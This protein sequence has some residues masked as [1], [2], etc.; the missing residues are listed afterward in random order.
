[1]ER[2]TCSQHQI[3][4]GKLKNLRPAFQREAGT[5]TAANASSLNDGA[6]ALVLMSAAR[7]FVFVVSA[8]FVIG[9]LIRLN[10]AVLPRSLHACTKSSFE[11]RNRCDL[12]IP[13]ILEITI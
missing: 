2:T 1:M 10:L 3:D 5:V 4:L 7:Y 9:S 6:A 13:E 11:K 8:V 12:E